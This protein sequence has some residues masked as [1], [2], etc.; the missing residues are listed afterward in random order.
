MLRGS[1]F[2]ALAAVSILAPSELTAGTD[3][4]CMYNC[5]A[6]GSSY[7]YCQKACDIP[8][9]PMSPPRNAPPVYFQPPKQTDFACMTGCQ[10]RGYSY[11]YCKNVCSY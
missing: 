7:Q 4:T 9:P 2:L 10:G 8:D 11:Q 5:T 1:I 3:F 6:R